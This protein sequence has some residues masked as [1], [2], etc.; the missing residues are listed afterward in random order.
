MTD[1]IHE[2]NILDTLDTFKEA[3]AYWLEKLAGEL[4]GTRLP[5]DFAETSLYR[6]AIYD[7]PFPSGLSGSVMRIGKSNDLAMFT[8]MLTA[9]KILLFKYTH[10]PDLFVASP[11]YTQTNQ[12]YNQ[13]V[14]FR[15]V[16]SGGATFKEL[17]MAVKQTVAGGFKNEHYPV[18]KLGD[19]LGFPDVSRLTGVAF[20][21]DSI[22]NEN[23]VTPLNKDILIA[24]HRKGDSLSASIR[25]N[26]A[27]F[28]EDTI[29]RFW[30][31]YCRLLDQVLENTGV[32]VDDIGLLTDEER[33]QV[34][35]RW[36]LTGTG[37]PTGETIHQAFKKQAAE[38]PGEIAVTSVMDALEEI[39]NC[40]C[41]TTP[42]FYHTDI[43]LPDES[44]SL[45][46][47]KTHL[48]D[49]F[50]VNP[51]LLHLL[52]AFNGETNVTAVYE[53]VKDIPLRFLVHYISIDDMLEISYGVQSRTETH[54]NDTFEDFLTLIK[55]LYTHKLIDILEVR[56]DTPG[57]DAD[58]IKGF[59]TEEAPNPTHQNRKPTMGVKTLSI[60]RHPKP[61]I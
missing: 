59:N 28:N 42:Y 2:D 27:L 31:H 46:V 6:E 51:N 4:T 8:I 1:N 38:T 22:H 23:F 19:A 13:W 50:I 18:A 21:L 32:T 9:L 48:H 35:V 33:E 41:K 34:L 29:G 45:V 25:Y 52:K 3:R 60:R 10:Q 5:A 58:F 40:C 17:L 20:L 12:Q 53:A 26:G 15:D 47:I 43:A 7:G 54:S 55:M 49:V 16:L 44:G 57:C 14:L 61:R 36:N 56:L 37:S 24:I 11:I 30:N 39:G